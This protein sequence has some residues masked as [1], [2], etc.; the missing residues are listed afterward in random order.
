MPSKLVVDPE[1][2]GK[3]AGVVETIG[4]F[5]VVLAPFFLPLFT[6]PLLLL[7]P[8]VPPPFDQVVD[9]LIGFTLAFHYVRLYNDLKVKQ[10]D[11]I[12]TGI[13]FSLV[14][15]VVMNLVF[16][17]VILVVVSGQYS[18]IPE[19]FKASWERAVTAYQA[20]YQAVR[21]FDLTDL[22]SLVEL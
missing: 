5:W 17:L 12:D 22:E 6:L 4:C 13:I 11:I 14:F 21:S 8:V 20:V 2:R 18:M 3:R 15:S 1:A 10:S 16:L 19:Y 9:F 7:K